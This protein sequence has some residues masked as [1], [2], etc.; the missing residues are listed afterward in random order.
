MLGLI[1]GPIA[2]LGFGQSLILSQ[3][4]PLIFFNRP[5]CIGLWI[6]TLLLMIPAF[7]SGRRRKQA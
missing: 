1:L 7:T 2:E 6:I 3:G 5:L 4:S